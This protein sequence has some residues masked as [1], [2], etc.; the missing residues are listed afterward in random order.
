MPN[1][2]TNEEYADMNFIYSFCD[3]N[4]RAAVVNY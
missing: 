3:G 2:F 1:I 4:G